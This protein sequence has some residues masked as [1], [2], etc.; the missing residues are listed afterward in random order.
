MVSHTVI[1][2]DNIKMEINRYTE[3]VW[4][5]EYIIWTNCSIFSENGEKIGEIM[6]EYKHI[7]ETHFPIT[8][9]VYCMIERLC[10][11]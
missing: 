10:I 8:G 11:Y 9:Q 5:E 1:N 7:R 3:E 4:D 6:V 2:S